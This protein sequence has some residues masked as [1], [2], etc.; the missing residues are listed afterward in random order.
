[1]L[2]QISHLSQEVFPL[3]PVNFTWTLLRDVELDWSDNIYSN[4]MR[5][6]SNLGF[7]SQFHTI[8]FNNPIAVRKV[9]VQKNFAYMGV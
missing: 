7:R 9:I 4:T 5:K 2:Q 1:M 8:T 3:V 6:D